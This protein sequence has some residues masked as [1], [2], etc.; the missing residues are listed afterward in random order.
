MSLDENLQRRQVRE[1]DGKTDRQECLSYGTP[2]E[3]N[4]CRDIDTYW[5]PTPQECYV[6]YFLTIPHSQINHKSRIAYYIL[7]NVFRL[8]PNRCS[9]EVPGH[10]PDVPCMSTAVPDIIPAVPKVS[11]DVPDSIPA[12]PEEST[13]V[14]EAIPDVLSQSTAVPVFIPDGLA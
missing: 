11:T 14:H 12:V 10:F 9:V 6:I 2:Q 5:F 4:V 3:C 13:G 7:K 1:S 8:L